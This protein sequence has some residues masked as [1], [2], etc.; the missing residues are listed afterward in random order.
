MSSDEQAVVSVVMP[1]HNRA[2]TVGRAIT[3]VLKQ[4]LRD[5]ELVVV[6]DGSDDGTPEAVARFGDPRI[7][8][9]RLP[10]NRGANAARNRGISE[11]RAPIISFL[12]SDDEFL[13]HKLRFVDEF[14]RTHAQVDV[15]IDS[16][17]LL[18][19]PEMGSR[20]AM[21]INPELRDSRR[22]EEAVFARKIYKATPALSLRRAAV[23]KVGP[24]DETLSRRQDMDLLLRLSRAVCCWSVA[25]VLWIKHWTEGAIS[26]KQ[27]TFM[28]ALIDICER[29]P[30]Y[31]SRPEFR[32]G[33]A[34]DFARHFLRLAA[35]RNLATIGRD[36]REFVA[37]RGRRE[38]LRLL[39]EGVAEKF[40]RSLPGARS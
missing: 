22:V 2:R 12:D 31:L 30:D 29:H 11:A 39:I 14:F 36:V 7:R 24:F 15:L 27:E 9:I 35:R 32:K 18:H 25:D 13:P 6:D 10:E 8:T 5:F 16:F 3:S 37:F 21:R 23:L 33:L 38:A 1:V 17:K 40:R 26:A 19:P 28:K 34:R 4:E 20:V